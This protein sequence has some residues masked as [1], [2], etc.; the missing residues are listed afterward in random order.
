MNGGGGA[1]PQPDRDAPSLPPEQP[2]K[3]DAP[4]A[5]PEAEAKPAGGG[6]VEPDRDDAERYL[7]AL[8]PT[9]DRFTFQTFDDNRKRKDKSLARVLHG[10]L[11]ALWNTLVKLNARGAGIY[12]CVN[13]TDFKG[14]SA[15][16]I[17]HV[18][19]HFGDL[20]GAPLEPV[21]APG[22]PRTHIITETSPRRWQFYYRVVNAPLDQFSAVQKAIAARHGGDN[23]VN[24][25]PRVM[26]V[27]G[28]IHRKGIPFRSRLVQASED[29]PYEWSEFR[30]AFPPADDKLWHEQR[31][32]NT[33]GGGDP[34]ASGEE[35]QADPNGGKAA[36]AGAPFQPSGRFARLNPDK[37]YIGEGIEE[38]PPLPFAPIKAECG[39][40]RHV[41]NTGGADQREPLWRDALR[42]C[43]FLEEGKRLIHELG[44][45][46]ADYNFADTEEKFAR[47]RADKE[48][49][50]LGWPRCQ[51]IH[52]D[53]SAHCKTCPHL[54]AGKSPLNLALRAPRGDGGNGPGPQPG[55]RGGGGGGGDYGG[56]G[57]GPQPDPGP[58]PSPQPGA[59]PG[60][61]DPWQEFI[62]PPFP[63]DILP[64]VAHEFVVTKS[65]AMGA[66]PSALAMAELAAFSGAI[67]HRF[68]V[69]MMENNDWYEHVRLWVLLFG[70]PSWLKS[71]IMDAVLRPIRLREGELRRDYEAQLCTWKAQ[72]KGKNAD[73]L[74]DGEE[75]P[76]QPE[77]LLVGDITTEMLC[78]VMSRSN[79]GSLAE[80]DELAG[81]IGRME[82]YHSG[83]KG[84]STDRAFYLRCWSGGPY[85]YDRKNSGEIRVPN[86]SL[87]ILGGIQPRRMDELQDLTSDGLLQRFLT[88]L[89]QAP[90]KPQDIDCAKIT[91]AYTRLMYELLKLPAQKFQ[92]TSGPGGAAEAM[93]E[94]QHDLFSLER[95]G[96]AIAEGFEGHIGKLKAYAGVLA[97][98]LHLIDN[99]AEAI[100]QGAIGKPVVEKVGRLIKEFLLP[101][102]REFYGRCQ[103]EGEQLR[104]I[105]SYVL[106]CGKD[107]IRLADLTNN[108]RFCRGKT[109]L[110]IN[111]QVSPLVAGDWLAPVEQSPVCRAWRVNRA[112]ID[113][114]FAAP[115][116]SERESKRAIVELLRARR[117][118]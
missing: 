21:L 23:A 53:G 98:I 46:H 16:N 90:K 103:G 12:V 29:E 67:H 74:G 118:V 20:D 78:E 72:H 33:N 117:H 9:T 109:V 17:T 69:K 49:K 43:M 82:R 26:R 47:A 64:G 61:F 96:A 30:K 15:E 70:R 63:L 54:P 5:F 97:I 28:F 57:P 102:A 10:T 115:M 65:T 38:L 50:D 66:D 107:R 91:S 31:D 2:S 113:Q 95:V 68:R 32:L 1:P 114:Q 94:L 93:S 92:L 4:K 100:R 24:D 39:W 83:G 37:G 99:P 22:E 3:A 75:K 88:T 11:A 101:H 73:G 56:D 76:E 79:R 7:T 27:P 81:W 8:D 77:R 80:H 6:A 71:P 51:T 108:V 35:A 59:Q 55:P 18:R 34:H 62:V 116:A 48:A 111:K 58:G 14:R 52:D 104:T 112:V 42:C 89:M 84:A 13:V 45:K 105:A 106:T 110:E 60:L 41:H 36:P 86:A 19:S 40:L 44:N 87:S 85:T 25:L